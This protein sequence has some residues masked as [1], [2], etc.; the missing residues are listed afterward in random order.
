M[1]KKHRKQLQTWL[2]LMRLAC[3][4]FSHY[5]KNEWPWRLFKVDK[6]FS[7]YSRGSGVHLISLIRSSLLTNMTGLYWI[8]LTKGWP[9]HLFQAGGASLYTS[10]FYG[11]FTRWNV[12]LVPLTVLA[13]LW[14]NVNIRGL[15][16][17]K[18]PSFF[19]LMLWVDRIQLIPKY[20]Y[21]NIIAFIFHLFP[22]LL[23]FCFSTKS[24]VLEGL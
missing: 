7:L 4:A 1:K 11:L 19:T 23:F 12:R 16:G 21:S 2:M 18:K 3:V 10:I 22:L 15:Q 5:K 20:F 24:L 6:M 9:N 14:T 17:D 8:W 13:R